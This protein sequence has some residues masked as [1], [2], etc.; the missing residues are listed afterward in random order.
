MFICQFSG[1][2]D[3]V[4]RV[5]I[6]FHASLTPEFFTRRASVFLALQAAIDIFASDAA[7]ISSSKTNKA[8]I[9]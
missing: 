8:M 3:V 6:S 9:F 2:N 1:V 4:L 5:K 7:N